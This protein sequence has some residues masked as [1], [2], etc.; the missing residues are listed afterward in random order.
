[1]RTAATIKKSISRKQAASGATTSQTK[2]KFKVRCSRYLYTF[3]ISDADKAAK[4]R[5]SLPPSTPLSSPLSLV[6]FTDT[7]CRALAGLKVTDVD[8]DKKSKK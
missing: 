3:V 2:Y 7:A 8:G 4:L 5:Q 1:M 6:L